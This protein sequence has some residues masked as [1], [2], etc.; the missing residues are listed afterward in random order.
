MKKYYIHL[1]VKASVLSSNHTAFICSFEIFFIIEET[2]RTIF[3]IRMKY[4]II[5]AFIFFI[6]QLFQKLTINELHKIF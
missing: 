2:T 3:V 4:P 1:V 6:C 5:A